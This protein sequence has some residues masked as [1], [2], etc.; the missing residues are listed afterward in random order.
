MQKIF[1]NC[2]FLEQCIILGRQKMAIC[3]VT[4]NPKSVFLQQNVSIVRISNEN[5][6]QTCV[7]LGV[8][9]LD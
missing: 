6:S 4:R 3:I 7:G 2:H 5:F 1:D 9:L 8:P